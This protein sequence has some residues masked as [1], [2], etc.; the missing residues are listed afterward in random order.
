MEFVSHVLWV[1][2]VTMS[3]WGNGAGI[4]PAATS[5]ELLKSCS[6]NLSNSKQ[7][8]RSLLFCNALTRN[9]CHISQ[10]DGT[11]VIANLSES[12]IIQQPRVCGCPR[13]NNLWSEQLGVLSQNVVVD[14][15]SSRIQLVWH[16]LEIDGCCRDFLLF[17]HET[18]R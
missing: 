9:M 6:W 14:R 13:N 4:T 16:G 11:H 8:N 17:S 2:V 12:W 5:P 1:V 3:A 15:S 7:H 10:H 18:M